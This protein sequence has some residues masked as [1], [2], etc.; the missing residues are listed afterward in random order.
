MG[1][2][3]VRGSEDL[4][5]PPTYLGRLWYTVPPAA[6]GALGKPSCAF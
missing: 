2:A 4:R 5:E 1:S 6:R 3:L